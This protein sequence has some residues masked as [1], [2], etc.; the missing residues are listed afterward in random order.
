MLYHLVIIAAYALTG[1]VIARQLPTYMP[2]IDPIISYYVGGGFFLVCAFLHDFINR[3][4]ERAQMKRDIQNLRQHVADAE[5]G[6]ARFENILGGLAGDDADMDGFAD[7]MKMLRKLLNQLSTEMKKDKISTSK[8]PLASQ[9]RGDV[10]APVRPPLFASNGKAEQAGPDKHEILEIVRSGLQDNRVDLYLQP[11]V[12]LPQR[13]THFYEAFS[14]IR[15]ENGEIITPGQYLPIAEDAGFIGTIDNLL[16]IRCVQLIRRIR[17]RNSEVAFFV[18]VSARTLRD[19]AFFHQFVEFLDR[20]SDLNKNLILE[21]SQEDVENTI[22]ELEG[23]LKMLA[24]MGFKFS[25]DR[26]TRLDLDFKKLG[27]DNFRY[28]KVA[29]ADL[30]PGS[31]GLPINIH[32]EDLQEALARAKIELIASMVEDED[33]VIGLLDVEVAFGQGYLFGVPRPPQ[34]STDQVTDAQD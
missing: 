15:G 24:E 19:T 4:V 9:V 23:G 6:L 10:S 3:K 25:M 20:N 29:A 22:P 30:L 1:A 28:L 33:T 13:R 7:E 32:L 14:R 21:F 26:I 16:L 31:D 12:R 34:R 2:N 8:Q 17:H 11:I 27:E 5:F 18:N